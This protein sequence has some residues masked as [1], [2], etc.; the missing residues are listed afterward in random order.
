[1]FAKLKIN[2]KQKYS[3]HIKEA[4]YYLE[5]GAIIRKIYE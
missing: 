4:R 1:M 3:K 2:N 5:L